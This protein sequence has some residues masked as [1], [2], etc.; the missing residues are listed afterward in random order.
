MHG[1]ILSLCDGSNRIAVISRDTRTLSVCRD[2]QNSLGTDVLLSHADVTDAN[3]VLSVFQD[4]A[5]WSP[6]LD[7]MIF[8]TIGL[9]QSE[10]QDC[11]SEEVTR[12]M[13]VT[14]H[15]FMNCVRLALPMFLRLGHG[16]VIAVQN[17]S[18]TRGEV[19]PASLSVGGASLKLYLNA[20]RGEFSTRAVDFTEIEL[21]GIP[22]HN[23]DSE[24][25]RQEIAVEIQ[26]VI[27]ERPERI[28]IVGKKPQ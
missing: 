15:G 10:P 3:A 14:L 27:T 17:S 1:V 7:R 22:N 25:L 11:E 16:H 28:R 20:L 19:R 24:W 13:R 6:R 26:K 18:G 4:I 9:A 2:L 23:I 21:I 5:K 8:D 12:G